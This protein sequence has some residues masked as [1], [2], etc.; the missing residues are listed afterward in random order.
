MYN[1]ELLDLVKESANKFCERTKADKHSRYMSWEHCY[2]EF[3]NARNRK[4]YSDNNID[5]LCLHLSV[6][7]ASWGMY[8][9][10]FL[11]QKDY[12]IHG[13]VVR[14]I[15]DTRYDVL[16]GITCR[17][18]ENEGNLGLLLELKEKIGG[19]CVGYHMWN[20][21]EGSSK[22]KKPADTLLSKILLG[23][24]GC[25]PAYDRYFRSAVAEHRF[26]T[27]IFSRNSVFSL[28]KFYEENEI[29][30]EKVRAGMKLEYSR[31]EY[32]QMK[33]L[34]MAFWKIGRN[35]EKKE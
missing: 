7:L 14:E 6:Y 10:S 26:A 8:R 22:I 25:V 19:Y 27:S 4:E 13:F 23:T 5:Y 16:C 15:L 30:L 12:K 11:L 28:C 24:L 33:L 3:L 18:L 17:E 21:E 31:I 2:S 35:L 20:G 32:P 29:E 1:R 34:D 9:N